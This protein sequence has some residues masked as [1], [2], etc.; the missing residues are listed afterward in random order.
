MEPAQPSWLVN[1]KVVDV[2]SGQITVGRNLEIGDGQIRSISATLP[3]AQQDVID[4]EG[5]FVL[6][7]LISCHTHLSVVFPM[8][9]TDPMENPAVTALRAAKRAGDALAAGITTVRCVHEQHRVDLWLRE[10]RRLG[11]APAPRIFGAG[12]AITTPKGHGAGAACVE[13][14]GE[15]EF[16]LAAREELEAGAD[17]VKIFINGGLAREGEDP[18]RSEMTD[19]ELRG[20]VRAA[21]RARHLRR[22]PLRCV[23]GYKTGL[24][25]GGPL[26]R[27]RL[28]ARRRHGHIARGYR[29]LPH[30]DAN[31]DPL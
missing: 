25:P 24:G 7:G 29:R 19:E 21:R 20:T 26:L 10:A 15:D 5:R 8:S 1:A 11:W 9:S 13:A 6:P 16:Y 4:V 3:P 30:A 18:S 23:A 12:Q 28:R 22:G 17:H 27:A 14:T 2:A 31:R